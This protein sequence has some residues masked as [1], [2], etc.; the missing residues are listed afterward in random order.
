LYPP[1]VWYSAL[2]QTLVEPFKWLNWGFRG[3][4]A[5]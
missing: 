3:F 5:E 1:K 2:S 4:I